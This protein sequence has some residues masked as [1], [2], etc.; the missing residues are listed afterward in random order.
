MEKE[1]V[2]F[3]SLFGNN[4]DIDLEERTRIIRELEK[5]G[6]LTF[7]ISKDDEGWTAQCKE[8]PAIITGNTNPNPT[9]TEIESQVRDAIYSAFNVKV[10]Q[11]TILPEFQK[12]KY[13]F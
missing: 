5:I 7:K 3:A 2:K 12:F 9:D 13:S 11:K 8:V 6:S 10:Q 1:N 4:T